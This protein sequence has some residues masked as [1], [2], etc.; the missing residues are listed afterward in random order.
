MEGSPG[1]AI[2][3]DGAKVPYWLGGGGGEKILVVHMSHRV[4]VC[5]HVSVYECAYMHYTSRKPVD[6]KLR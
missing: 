1:T 4:Y 5:V 6:D 3:C 2:R